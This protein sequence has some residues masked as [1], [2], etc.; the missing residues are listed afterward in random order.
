MPR[1]LLIPELVTVASFDRERAIRFNASSACRF[2]IRRCA[3]I[4]FKRSGAL[5]VLH[6][7]LAVCLFKTRRCPAAMLLLKQGNTCE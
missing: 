5:M 4:G 3:V 6:A 1:R 2:S 7:V